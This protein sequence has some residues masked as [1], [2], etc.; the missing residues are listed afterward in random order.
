MKKMSK[1]LRTRLVQ[2][3]F[4][5]RVCWTKLYRVQL[6]EDPDCWRCQNG[7]GTLIHMLWSW[8][9]IQ[10]C[11]WEIHSNITKIIGCDMPFF[12]RLYI[13]RDPSLLD[14]LPPHDAEWVQVA[15]M[16]G[17]KL[18]FSV[19]KAS[20]P[21]PVNLWH[22]HLARLAALEGLSHRLINS[23]KL[24]NEMGMIFIKL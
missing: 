11:W 5:N 18:I 8:Q 4:L 3:K 16:L 23:G 6:K 10:D 7:A 19:S 22:I 24:L 13:L 17:S 14:D 21:P 20:S 15:L 12:Q 9:K 1:E 2:F